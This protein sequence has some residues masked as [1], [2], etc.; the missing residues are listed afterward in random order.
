MISPKLQWKVLSRIKIGFDNFSRRSV[1]WLSTTLDRI[2]ARKFRSEIIRENGESVVDQQL[3]KDIKAYCLHQFGRENYWPWIALYAEM[4]GEYKHGWIPADY[5]RFTLLRKFNPDTYSLLSRN[6]CFDHKLFSEFSLRPILTRVS[7]VY[8]DSA[9]KRV[10]EENAQTL[11][12]NLDDEVVLKK[13]GGRG[14][15]GLL[16]VHSSDLHLPG[17]YKGNDIII[18][19]LLKQCKTLSSIHP[20]SVNTLRVFTYLNSSGIVEVLVTVLR[21][22]IGAS[23]C[24]GID[25]G[26]GFCRVGENG[27]V[28]PVYFNTEG[29]RAGNKHPDTGIEF[30]NLKIPNIERLLSQCISAHESYPFVRFIGWDVAI[31]EFQNPVLLEWNAVHPGFAFFEALFGPLIEEDELNK[32]KTYP[33]Q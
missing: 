4:R 7:G 2:K 20:E 14:G 6:K 9:N 1:V 12:K 24:D 25:A 19:P 18:Q 32:F 16:F 29:V 15:E 30:G 10:T 8:Y 17:T 23:K 5:Y 21:F 11:L 27:I 22:G 26:G 3:M 31:D 33:K 28:D 13:D